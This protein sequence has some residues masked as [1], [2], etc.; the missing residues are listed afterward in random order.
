M[1]NG[2]PIRV[3]VADVHRIARYGVVCAL[4]TSERFTVV[5][6]ASDGHQAA[7]DIAELAPDVAVLAE[8][9]GPVSALELLAELPAGCPTRVILLS[10]RLDHS[11]VYAALAAG[12][13]GYLTARST[14][15]A[16]L[17]ETVAAAASDEISLDPAAQRVLATV[18]HNGHEHDLPALTVRERDVIRLAADGLQTS[19][20]AHDLN[21]GV[22]TVKKHQQSAY[23]KL[24]VCTCAGAVAKALRLTLIS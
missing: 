10:T 8:Q 12:A 21:I 16:Q 3:Y 14:H 7:A 22:T 19:Q 20:I 11:G 18:I 17:R 9:L 23:E 2:Q 13:T 24:G 1:D 6:E 4:E 15:S 5:G